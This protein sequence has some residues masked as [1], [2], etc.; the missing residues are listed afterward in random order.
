[1]MKRWGV[2][3]VAAVACVHAD[4]AIDCVDLSGETARHSV[5]AAG[6][7]TL[8]NGH[9]ST[10]LMPDGSATAKWWTVPVASEKDNCVF[11]D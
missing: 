2:A 3:V 6:T 10:I 9:P 5:V 7:P 4:A 8:Y 1:M 11:G